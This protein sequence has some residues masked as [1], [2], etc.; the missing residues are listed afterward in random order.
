MTPGS[1]A[2]T[3]LAAGILTVTIGSCYWSSARQEP[4]AKEVAKGPSPS[5]AREVCKQFIE[6]S[7]YKVQD[8]GN[9]WDWTTIDNKD[10]T[11]SVGARFMGAAPG[12]VVRNL[13][14]TCIAAAQDSDNW[15]LVKLSRMQ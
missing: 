13:Y 2:L 9:S 14:V 10:G 8:W 6:R 7:G 15:K 5:S 1:N 12:G 4:P 3:W 11:W